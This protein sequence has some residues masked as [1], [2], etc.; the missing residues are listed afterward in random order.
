MSLPD[1]IV[2]LP[3]GGI[4][5]IGSL[6]KLAAGA[7]VVLVAVSIAGCSAVEAPRDLS[8]YQAQTIAWDSC[9]SDLLLESQSNAFESATVDCATM[10][11]PAV[12]T[13]DQE[14]KDFRLQLMRIHKAKSADFMGTIFI[15]P[16]GPGGSGVEQV[17]W[18]EF[19]AELLAHYDV[20]GFD[21]RGVGASKFADGTEIKCTDK[22]DYATYFSGEATPANEQE[23]LSYLESNDAYY[24]DCIEKNPLWWTMSTE[25]VVEDL[26]LMRQVVTG[27]EDL[28]FIG[29]SYGTTIAGI[30]VTKYP[31]HVGKI[32]LD[33]PTTVDADTIES[34]IEDLKALEKKLDIYLSNYA[35]HAAITKDEAWQRLL[36]VRQ[37]A[38][39]DLIYGF[40]GIEAGPG[41]MGMVSSESLLTRGIL[42]LNYMPEEDA[43][44][45]F[46]AALDDLYQYAWNARFE[47]YSFNLDGYDAN[48]L[49][50]ATL[51]AKKFVRSNEYEVMAIV[52]T[53]DFAPAEKSSSERKKNYEL[54]KAAAPKWNQLN[55]DS[56]GYVYFGNQE[57]L[58]WDSIARADS[59]IPD[60]PTEPLARTNTSGKQLLIVGA[61]R[62]AVT[63]FSF[64]KATA[65][66]LKSPLIAVDSATHGPAAGYDIPCLNKILVEFFTT[67]K[68]I[69]SQSCPG[70]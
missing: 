44:T 70:S 11:A 65:K 8:T 13:G 56:T 21:P 1:A 10:L 52:N 51:A 67:E 40:A 33:S 47:W 43:I 3:E 31:D 30:Y 14:V 42:A 26:E 34:D 9:D 22:L 58:G 46:N 19:P 68:S 27:D 36:D 6:K 41:D 49:E 37:Q 60:P 63:P 64:S 28:N 50:G 2:D 12:Y 55:S 69:K 39:N 54:M 15:N 7:V 38:D 23:A 24:K 17:Q 25:H 32:V 5:S 62:E 66:L 18:S 16:G 59:A 61:T 35:K 29:S 57:G 20:I 45:E 48:E 53:M 4:M